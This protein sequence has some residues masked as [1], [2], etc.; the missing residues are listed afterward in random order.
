[1]RARRSYPI[2]VPA[3]LNGN[4]STAANVEA[5]VAAKQLLGPLTEEQER[6]LEVAAEAFFEQGRRWPTFQY[7]EAVLERE[8]LNARS[9]LAT[10]PV[11]GTTMQYAAC[12][13]TPWAGSLSDD[14]KVELTL[15]G[16][17]RYEGVFKANADA[18]VRD[19]LRLLK[20][21][22]DARRNFVPSPTE[23]KHLRLSSEEVLERLRDIKHELPP[24]AVLAGFIE[25]E[26][27]LAACI[28]G[29]SNNGETWTWI[30]Q[31]GTLLD[32]DGV[33][34]NV[35][36][37]VRRIATTYHV[38]RRVEQRVVASPLTLPAALGYLDAAWRVMEGRDFHLVV[39]PS[40]D[41]AA[42][43]AFDAGTRPEFLERVGALGDVLKW[44]R[45]PA[46]GAQQ[47]GHPLERLRA[48]L[49]WRLP[50]ESH[51]RIR[52]AI[53]QLG[54]VV[55]IRNGGLHAEA[56]PAALRAYQALGI[57]YPVTDGGAAW[58]ALR[59]AAVE[60]V[61]AIREEVLSYTDTRPP[62]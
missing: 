51:E 8:G 38:S 37:Y 59:A 39:L 29:S 61:D 33:G 54:D 55:A 14:S 47:G 25:T 52:G 23:V 32:F 20:V 22:I 34:L 10:F 19:G 7:V 17:H 2:G 57:A 45:V 50:T 16:L 1:M 43:L 58:N 60:A 18:L 27:P 46:G 6:V 28:G 42:S 48:Y 5:E 15:L 13:C 31:R 40:P 62:S 44:L 49:L 9:V 53:D 4:S 12:R 30:V 24:A 36:E 41:R 26:P 11:A 35:D 21:F 3:S 56:E